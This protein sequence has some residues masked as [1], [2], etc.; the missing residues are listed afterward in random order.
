MLSTNW[1]GEIIL[2]TF[3]VCDRIKHERNKVGNNEKQRKERKF[4]SKKE[5]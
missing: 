5:L 4:G 1:V 3:A 2:K